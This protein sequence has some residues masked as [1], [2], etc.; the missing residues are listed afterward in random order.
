VGATAG[1][2]VRDLAIDSLASFWLYTAAAGALVGGTRLRPLLAAATVAVAALWL[3]V[4]FTPLAALAT[5]GLVRRDAV[6]PAD[7]VLVMASRLQ[8]DGEPTAAAQSRLVHGVELLGQGLAP[9]LVVTEFAPPAPSSLALAR[10]LMASFGLSREVVAMGPA[11]TTRTEA[12]LAAA[13]C[14]EKGW[15]R[16]LLVTSPAHSMRA[17]AAVEREGVEVICSPAPET[18]YD[19]QTLER[20]MER[21]AAFRGMLH[22]RLGLWLYERRGWLKVTDLPWRR[23]RYG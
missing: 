10:K 14:R 20:P 2:L 8:R 12:V 3:A 13:L 5:R 9:R 7:A 1:F 15:R 23:L 19:L 11:G 4:A 18:E 6:G 21:F 16:L 22:E 17:C